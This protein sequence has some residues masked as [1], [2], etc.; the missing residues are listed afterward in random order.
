MAI[1]T[2]GSLLKDSLNRAGIRKQVDSS[3]I[4]EKF[5]EVLISILE[6]ELGEEKMKKMKKD[7][8]PLYVKNRVLTVASL[9]PCVSQEIKLREKTI[10]YKINSEIG[11]DLVDKIIFVV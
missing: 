3:L 4:L 9:N 8:K 1:Q 2:L 11:E 10:I 5:E 6:Q 7:I